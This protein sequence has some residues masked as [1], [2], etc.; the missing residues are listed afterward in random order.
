[1]TLLRVR[2]T[3]VAL[4]LSL[5]L[6]AGLIA[7]F[8]YQ[9]LDSA[10]LQSDQAS[11]WRYL[12]AERVQLREMRAE[13]CRNTP[14]PTRAELLSWESMSRP[15]ERLSEPHDKDGLLWLRDIGVKLDANERLVGVCPAMTWQALDGP[16]LDVWDNAG[17]NCPLEPL[18]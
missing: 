17:E 9:T 15:A 2:W 8:G 18:C 5:A 14:N 11:T 10:H 1:M 6:N 13:F 7:L 12:T 16:E 4:V 3:L